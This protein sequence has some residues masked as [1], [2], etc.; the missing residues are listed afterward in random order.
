MN[1][2]FPYN[3]GGLVL[4]CHRI[5]PLLAVALALAGTAAHAQDAQDAPQKG[6]YG[7]ARGGATVDA[8]QSL[9]SAGLPTN[10]T[11]DQKTRHNTAPTGELGAG[12]S[13][14]MFRLE[15]TVGYT[16][17]TPRN[18][19]SGNYTGSGRTNALTLAVSGFVDIPTGTRFSPFLGAGVGAARVQSHLSRV[20]EGTGNDSSYDGNKFGLLWHADAGVGYRISQHLTAELSGRYTSISNLSFD[21]QSNGVSVTYKP[22]IGYISALAGVRYAF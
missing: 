20:D 4:A 7:V 6:W 15:Q 10:V 16:G 3:L 5:S 9:D 12:Y 2:N 11:F 18:L 8:S 19:T 21:G 14:G 17:I 1:K 13:F 22:K